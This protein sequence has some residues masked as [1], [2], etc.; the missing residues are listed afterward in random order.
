[1][2]VAAFLKA[3][4]IPLG[5]NT[6]YIYGDLLILPLVRIYQRSFPAK[7]TAAFLALFVLGAC[8]AGAVMETAFSII[9]TGV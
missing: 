3:A 6:T 5:A 9:P 2:P 8:A 7:L 4:G 1:V